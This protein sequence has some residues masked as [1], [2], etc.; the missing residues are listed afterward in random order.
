MSR[1]GAIKGAYWGLGLGESVGSSKVSLEY[2]GQVYFENAA[3]R[4]T[5]NM[6]NL[7]AISG[8]RETYHSF[9]IHQS[10]ENIKR[11][12]DYYGKTRVVPVAITDRYVSAYRFAREIQPEEIIDDI[13]EATNI[14]QSDDYDP[15]A[16]RPKDDRPLPEVPEKE[17]GKKAVAKR[18]RIAVFPFAEYYTTSEPFPN[19]FSTNLRASILEFA[20]KQEA[21]LLVSEWRVKNSPRREAGENDIQYLNR[22][23]KFHSADLL[24]L[25]ALEIDHRETHLKA[26]LVYFR[27][28]DKEISALSEYWNT[29]ERFEV[30]REN[31][32]K[33]FALQTSSLLDTNLGDR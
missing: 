28:N 17:E 12:T 23:C 31:V 16:I 32:V 19:T 7:A 26:R 1:Q 15:N 10:F 4:A 11:Y 5:A 14:P 21:L 3:Y 20:L 22:L 33:D 8:L 9:A 29:Y 18:F 6:E 24:L 27:A 30:L 2:A 13:W 25:P